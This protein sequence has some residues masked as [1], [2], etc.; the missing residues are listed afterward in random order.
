MTMRALRAAV[1]VALLVLVA[2]CTETPTV[3]R[4]PNAAPTTAEVPPSVDSTADL[5]ALK[6]AAGI[7]DCPVSD[8]DVPAVS[9][10]LPDVVVSCLGGGRDVRLAGLRG[11]P[12]LISLWAQWCSPCRT[13]APY[14]AEVSQRSGSKLTVL[15]VDFHDGYPDRA[16]EFARL[17]K[18][19]YPQVVDTGAAFAPLQ[20]TAPPVTFLVRADGTIADQ[21]FGGFRS[22]EEMT[23]LVREKLGVSL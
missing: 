1:L 8:A 6:K 17:A 7:G 21:H 2:G 19:D 12:M 13:E 22:T 18:W 9:N 5:A 4:L 16:L 20:V 3:T 15:G 14:L 23:T 11:R 10:G